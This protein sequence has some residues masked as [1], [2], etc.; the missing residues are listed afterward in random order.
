MSVKSDG[1]S[2]PDL[3]G[4]PDGCEGMTDIAEALD[5][6]P[7]RYTIFKA[8]WRWGGKDGTALMYDL[9]KIIYAAG[10]AKLAAMDTGPPTHFFCEDCRQPHPVGEPHDCP[11]P[12]MRD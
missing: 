11:K 7:L 4:V 5:M 8:V 9:N 3:Y 6:R 10:R 2:T 12:I 1:G